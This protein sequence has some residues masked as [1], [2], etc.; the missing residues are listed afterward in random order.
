MYHVL[1][2]YF[3]PL[4]LFEIPRLFKNNYAQTEQSTHTHTHTQ[5]HTYTHTPQIGIEVYYKAQELRKAIKILKR[6]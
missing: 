4:F 1:K 6:H 2:M 5:T 3:S